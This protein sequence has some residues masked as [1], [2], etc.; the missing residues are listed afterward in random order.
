VQ[1]F[2]EVDWLIGCA[3]VRPLSDQELDRLLISGTD[4]TR[5]ERGPR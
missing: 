3:F 1:R 5:A 4:R 2:S